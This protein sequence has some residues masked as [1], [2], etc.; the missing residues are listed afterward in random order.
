M[1]RYRFTPAARDD[2]KA[3]SSYIAVE[4]QSP[5]G[6]RRLRELFFD[7]FRRVARDPL[8]GQAWPELGDNV[9]IWPVRSYLVIYLPTGEGIDIV[10]IAH[11]AQDLPTVIRRPAAT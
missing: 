9:R 2:L 5:Q 11:G 10:Q 8:I 6:A 1:K 7:D 4:K 3:I